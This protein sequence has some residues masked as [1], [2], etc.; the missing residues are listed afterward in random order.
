MIASQHLHELLVHC[1]EAGKPSSQYE[2]WSNV[3]SWIDD[4]TSAVMKPI[5]WSP[6]HPGLAVQHKQEW[7]ISDL[8]FLDITRLSWEWIQICVLTTWLWGY[9]TTMP[10]R[11]IEDATLISEQ[12]MNRRQVRGDMTEHRCRSI[13]EIPEGCCWLYFTSC[14]SSSVFHTMSS[15]E[16]EKFL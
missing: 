6:D 1:Q 15:R 11:P 2:H 3:V 13:S 14:L 12:K 8:L 4:P 9:Q 10:S 7:A 16:L 5:Q